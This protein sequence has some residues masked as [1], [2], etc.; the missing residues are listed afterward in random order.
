MAKTVWSNLVPHSKETIDAN[1]FL[2]FPDEAHDLPEDVNPQEKAWM[3]K[4]SRTAD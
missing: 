3:M 4:L 1:D 2:L